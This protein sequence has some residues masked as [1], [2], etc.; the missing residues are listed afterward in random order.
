MLCL[1]GVQLLMVGTVGELLTQTH[2]ESGVDPVY[3]FERVI[4]FVPKVEI[5]TVSPEKPIVAKRAVR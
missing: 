1:F 2:F 5:T 4:G 3:R